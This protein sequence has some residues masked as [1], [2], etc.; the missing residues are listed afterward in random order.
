MARK[1]MSPDEWARYEAEADAQVERL[2]A[3]AKKIEA[4]LE[5][6]RLAAERPPPRRRLFGLLS[7]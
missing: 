1:R 4:E 5:E 7:R 2:R 6:K 3:R